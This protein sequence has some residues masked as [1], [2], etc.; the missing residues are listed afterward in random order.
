MPGDFNKPQTTEQYA[1]VLQSVRDIVAD[2]AKGLDGTAT[3]N[4]PANALRWGSAAKRW[5]RW[6]GTAWVELVAKATDKYDINVDRVDGYDAAAAPTANTLP[7]RDAAGK[8]PGDIT[9]TAAG[10]PWSGITGKPTTLSGYGITDAA[11]KAGDAA[12]TFAVANATAASH[13]VS[14]GYGD[15]RYAPIAQTLGAG[16]DLTGSMPNP[17]LKTTGVVAGSYTNANIT[18]DAKGRITAA[19]NGSPGNVGDITGGSNVGSGVGTFYT[20]SGNTLQF[21]SVMHSNPAAFTSRSGSV[22]V[23]AYDNGAGSIVLEVW[24]LDGGS[25]I[26]LHPHSLIL[27]ADGSVKYLC[28]VRPG[29]RVRTPAGADVVAG[30]WTSAL[31]DRPLVE[32]NRRLVLTPDHLVRTPGGWAA[33]KPE[34]YARRDHG[35]VFPIKTARGMVQ[36][37]CALADPQEVAPL[38]VGAVVLTQEG[39]ETVTEIREFQAPEHHQV[40][41]LLLAR[42]KVFFSDGF[43]VSTLA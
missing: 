17:T 38:V 27:M 34:E 37:T 19:G 41:A 9:G 31:A 15:S 14:Q 11:P 32:I 40:L 18:V 16:S 22:G 12:Q 26:C 23:K 25:G 4:V 10:A 7:V 1:A 21:R 2:V 3:A 6:N 43:A 20:K 35:K 24:N 39:Q 33:L 30:V 28:D 5:E 36:A 29:D 13:A 8:L 42:E